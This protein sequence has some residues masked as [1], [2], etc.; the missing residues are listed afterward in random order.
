MHA[1]CVDT[2][3]HQTQQRSMHGTHSMPM[4]S[5]CQDPLF[6][7]PLFP[8][9]AKSWNSLVQ[10][11]NRLGTWPAL[12]PAGVASCQWL[13][14]IWVAILSLFEYVTQSVCVW[15]MAQW[16]IM[17]CL[18]LLY[19]LVPGKLTVFSQCFQLRVRLNIK[20]RSAQVVIS[21]NTKDTHLDRKSVV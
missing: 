12:T 21:R 5:Q 8:V 3:T 4:P 9:G 18:L 14:M 15:N 10:N 17:I 16:N 6:A 20:V 13:N 19:L 7:H 2:Q 1:C 11:L